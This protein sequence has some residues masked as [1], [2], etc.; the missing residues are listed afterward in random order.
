[1]GAKEAVELPGND[2]L[3]LFDDLAAGFPLAHACGVF[4]MCVGGRAVAE[5]KERTDSKIK[6]N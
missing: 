1:M 3:F 4:W 5:W 2:L 6:N